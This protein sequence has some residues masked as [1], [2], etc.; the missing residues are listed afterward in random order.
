MGVLEARRQQPARDLHHLGAGT[1]EVADVLVGTDGADPA[2]THRDTTGHRR[3]AE[4]GEDATTD[5][6][7]ICV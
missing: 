7:Q 1:H 3:G 6:D 2:P 5:E 4:P